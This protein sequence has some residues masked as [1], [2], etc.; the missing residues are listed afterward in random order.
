MIY[1]YEVNMCVD[2]NGVK[3]EV[4]RLEHAYNV[5]DAIGQA[6]IHMTSEY[7]DAKLTILRIG[8]PITDIFEGEAKRAR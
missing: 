5:M 7:V 8:P 1:K 4:T 2:C 3:K 6:C